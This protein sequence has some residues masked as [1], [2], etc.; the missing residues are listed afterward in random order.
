MIPSLWRKLTSLFSEGNWPLLTKELTEQAAHRRNYIMRV[1]FALGIYAV[2][3]LQ[4]SRMLS[5]RG[6]NA[7]AV[8][9][10]GQEM[11]AN[12]ISSMT[13]GIFLFMP[14]LSCASIAHEKQRNTLT[15]LLITKLSPMSIV[16]QKLIGRLLVMA[17]VLLPA[18]PLLAFTYS[19]GGIGPVEFYCG[20]I[21]VSMICVFVGSVTVA[22]SAYAG[23]V[24]SAFISS[25]AAGTVLLLISMCC[26]SPS[27]TLQFFY[28]GGNSNSAFIASTIATVVVAGA[29][30]FA[31]VLA[32]RTYIVD[33]AFVP[34]RNY[35]LEFFQGMDNVYR[36]LNSV[37]GGIE[38][39]KDKESL[40]VDKPILWRE[41][42]KKALGTIR[43]LVRVFLIV[44]VP[45]L[46]I[47]LLAEGTRG[48]QGYGAAVFC[49]SI[50][51]ILTVLLVSVRSTSIIA[52]ERARQTLDV[53]L[54]LPLTGRDI[55]LQAHASVRRLMLIMC[56]PLLTVFLFECWWRFDVYGHNS[57]Q[58][59]LGGI[60]YYLIVSVGE[61]IIF[62][63]LC[64]WLGTLI[65]LFFRSQMQ[66]IMITLGMTLGWIF[67]PLFVQDFN[68]L[69]PATFIHEHE[70]NGVPLQYAAIYLGSYAML[71]AGLRYYCLS[72]SDY[73]LGRLGPRSGKDLKPSQTE[74]ALT[75]LNLS[76]KAG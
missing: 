53:L 64:A 73:L 50:I 41:N 68:W 27:V 13:L 55:L 11:Y 15:L 54:T 33:R 5:M 51:W 69:S 46:F 76:G 20:L 7:F 65:G 12:I 49:L 30:S 59:L 37:T 47:L 44:E 39:V 62:L 32:A 9:G 63:P 25:Y 14:A 28:A 35:M 42:T 75:P 38:V 48:G 8:L 57:R 29:F 72:R 19:L 70:T 40:P 61:L 16:V 6:D 1:L 43:Y 34:P 74:I 67:L 31:S 2:F 18:V 21:S 17:S 4:Y 45:T 36:G 10:H 52:G 71:M 22:A 56:V 24:F 58:E 3:G 26:I 66:A 23:S 60:F